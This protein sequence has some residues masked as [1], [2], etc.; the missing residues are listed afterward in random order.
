MARLLRHRQ[1]KGAAT[2]R[3]ILPPPRHIPT[4]PGTDL[5]RHHQEGL[6]LEVK[7]TK[8]ARKRTSKLE[9]PLLGAERTYRRHGPDFR[10]SHERTLAGTQQQPQCRTSRCRWGEP[11]TKSYAA[12]RASDNRRRS[13]ILYTVARIAERS[14]AAV[15]AC[16]DMLVGH[17]R[18]VR[19]S[20]WRAETAPSASVPCFPRP[21]RPGPCLDVGRNDRH[22]RTPQ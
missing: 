21:A 12:I 18:S 3:P 17:L 11:P 6:L 15:T 2:D 20:A 1:T 4:L 14:G 9:G 13:P 22:R 8:S 7:R 16:R 10:A 5:R 19:K